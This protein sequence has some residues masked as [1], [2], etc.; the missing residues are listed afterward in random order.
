M[1]FVTEE[2]WQ[3]LKKQLPSAWQATESIMV[4]A[5]PAA[6]ETAI[7]PQAEQVME[8]IIEI[9][10]SIRNARAQYRVESTRWI[11]AQVY[12]DSSLGQAIAPYTEA[13]KT[14]ARA[15]PVTFLEGGP[16]EAGE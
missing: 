10:H 11:E 4:S 12:A 6:D 3:H 9:I 13:I 1:P 2:L 8:C 5:Y 16:G 7:D 15:N 14:L